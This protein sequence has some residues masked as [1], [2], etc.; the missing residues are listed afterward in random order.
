VPQFAAVACVLFVA[1]LFWDDMRRRPGFRPSWAPLAWMFLAGSRWVSSWLSLGSPMSSVDSYSEGSPVD[2]AVFFGLILWGLAVL[3][4]RNINW[5]RLLARNAWLTLYLLFC[6][7]SV[8]WSDEPVV[9]VKRWIKD[10]GN[11]I[12]ALVILTEVRPYEALGITLRRLAF[13]L[14]PLS[15]VFVRYFPELGRTYH[16]DGT[17]MFTGVG[18]QKNDLGLMCL[19]TGIYF[20]WK[21]I[22]K[23]GR[24]SVLE[25]FDRWDVVLMAMMAWLLYMS[26]SQ[27]S[28]TCLLVATAIMVAARLP[29][30]AGRPGRLVPVVVTAAVVLITLQLTIG[31]K[32]RILELL[33]RDASLTNRTQLWDVVLAQVTNPFLGSGF[34]SFW[35]GARMQAVWDGMNTPGINQAHSGY[36]EQ[37]VNLGVVGVA[38]IAALIASS[39]FRIGR[40]S[41]GDSAPA[42]LRL[43]LVVVAAMYNYTEASFYGINNMWVLFLIATLNVSD[44]VSTARRHVVSL[45]EDDDR[46]RRI[47]RRRPTP[48]AARVHSPRS[49][50]GRRAVDPRRRRTTL[51]AT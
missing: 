8:L 33:G 17:S 26:N 23:Q 44:V 48:V 42:V 16:V 39:L 43:A 22:Q 47:A 24:T 29:P 20:A 32:D 50:A 7:S 18:H 12:M 2:R 14:L 49:T 5:G 46:P 3:A 15:V 31:L 4:R 51:L 34:M 37:Y 30:I 1:F 38:F 40:L 9:L 28:L 13:L 27:T 41:V 11:P 21:L 45:D 35:T 25:A 6:L 36:I 10:L 19:I